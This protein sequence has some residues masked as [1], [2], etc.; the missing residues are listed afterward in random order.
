MR[1]KLRRNLNSVIAPLRITVLH[2]RITSVACAVTSVVYIW[3]CHFNRHRTGQKLNLFI[4][5]NIRTAKQAGRKGAIENKT[6]VNFW[7]KGYLLK[8]ILAQRQFQYFFK[9]TLSPV[10][11]LYINFVD[12]CCLWVFK[13]LK[14]KSNNEN[15]E[16]TDKYRNLK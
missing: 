7:H 8:F 16:L 9:Y 6:A 11:H 5:F 10:L 3:T 12:F 13:T 2:V 1:C 15:K 4:S 14:K